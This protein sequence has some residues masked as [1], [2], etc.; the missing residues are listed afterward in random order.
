MKRGG[1]Y[2]LA[3]GALALMLCACASTKLTN[4][5][6]DSG[7]AGPPLTKILVIGV[8]KQSGIRRTF[9]DIFAEQLRA[10][11]VDP[12][13][14][15][16][17]IP[18]DGEVPQERLAQAVH[19]SSA[20]GLL[21][22]RL[23]KVDRQTQYYPGTYVGPRLGGFYGFY[24]LAWIGFYDPPQVY[25]YDVVTSETSLFEAKTNRLLWSGTSETFSPHD[26]KKDTSEFASVILKAL[27]GQ[28][29]VPGGSDK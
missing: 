6:R 21:I 16:T 13:Q 24:S 27:A 1:I 8:T 25:T 20:Q 4:S 12:I 7:Y 23:V 19:E 14:S 26:V 5:W 18:D 10:H 11:H 9:E 2:T 3:L 22:T 17:L 28:G 15:Y 29:L